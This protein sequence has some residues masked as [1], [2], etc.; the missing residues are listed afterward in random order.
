[1]ATVIPQLSQDQ[2]RQAR[3]AAAAARRARAE[4]KLDLRQGRVNLAQAL[5]QAADD[6][7]LAHIKVVDLLRSVNRVGEKRAA[8]VMRRAGIAANR[9]VRGLGRRQL[10]SLKAAFV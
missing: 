2:L 1:V 7:V 4:L 6:P 8:E 10:A 3:L 9:R 5:D